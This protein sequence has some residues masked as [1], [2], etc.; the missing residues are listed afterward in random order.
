MKN[1]H[2]I[3]RNDI[4]YHLC[5]SGEYT[6]EQIGKLYGVTGERIR[7]VYEKEA[8]IR[9]QNRKTYCSC[10]VEYPNESHKYK[11]G[12]WKCVQEYKCI[13]QLEEKRRFRKPQK[14]IC[15]KIK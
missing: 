10:W 4:I 9:K 1:D 3:T 7:Q 14:T 15:E 6:D 5:K 13:H 12:H 11:N 8:N 2:E